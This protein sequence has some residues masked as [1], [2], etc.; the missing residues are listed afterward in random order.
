MGYDMIQHDENVRLKNWQ[1]AN[2]VYRKEENKCPL[3]VDTHD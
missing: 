2:I 3:P 1:M